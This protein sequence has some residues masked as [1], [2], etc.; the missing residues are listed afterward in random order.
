[1]RLRFLFI[2]LMCMCLGSLYSQNADIRLLRQINL[3]RNTTLDPAFKFITNTAVPLSFALPVGIYG[4]GMIEMDPSLRHKALYV[5]ASLVCTS[6]LTTAL[7]YTIKR[8]RP[9]VTYPDLEK[10]TSGGSPS[11]PSGH[12]SVAFSTA[13]SLSFEFPKWY[14]IAPSYAWASAVA[15]SRMDLGVHYPSDV[16]AGAIVGSGSAL[17]CHEAQKWFHKKD[18]LPLR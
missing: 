14:V 4:L 17:L 8:D 12:A 1:M 13:T 7:K 6:L 9:Y 16:L 5:G 2:L 15:Y 18:K 10:E 3:H 11:F